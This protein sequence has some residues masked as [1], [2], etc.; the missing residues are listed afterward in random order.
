[1]REPPWKTLVQDLKE[2]GRESVYLDRLRDRL[3]V[4]SSQDELK[5]EILREMA[6]ALGRSEDKVNL[7]LLRLERI[8]ARIESLRLREGE[9]PG[10]AQEMDAEIDAF[11]EQ[12]RQALHHLWELTIH[13]EAL[14]LRRNEILR[15]LYPLPPRKPLRRR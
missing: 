2:S 1:M 3:T 9:A 13:R 10:W 6:S 5:K 14:G 7:A 15:D 4:A 12:R 8:E 11:N